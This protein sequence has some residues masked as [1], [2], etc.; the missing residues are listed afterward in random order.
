MM[1]QL[2]EHLKIKVMMRDCCG[3]MSALMWIGMI[4]G[5]IVLIL[6]ILWLIKQIR[7]P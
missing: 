1:F 2:F 6:L 3:G 4:A 5:T 7:K